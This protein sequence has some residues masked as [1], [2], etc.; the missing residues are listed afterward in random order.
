MLT[1]A[2]VLAFLFASLTMQCALA[3]EPLSLSNAATVANAD[4]ALVLIHGL[5]GDPKRSFGKW[6]ELIAQDP[7]TLA[8][9]GKLS[10]VAIYA[11]DYTADFKSMSTLEEVA[12]GAAADLAASSIFRK[13][14]HVWFVAHSMGGLVLKRTFALWKLQGKTVLLDRVVGV[15]MLGVPAA[16]APLADLVTSVSLQKVATFF[17]WNGDLVKELTTESGMRYLDSLENDWMS[18]RSARTGDSARR[19]TPYVSCGYET[20]PQ[21]GLASGLLPR[22]LA[23]VVP[24]LF[25]S[26]ICDER[27]GFSVRHTDL[28]EPA[29]DGDSIHLWLRGF[30][31]R[32]SLEGFKERRVSLTTA[33][34]SQVASFVLGRV[35]H[36][37]RALETGNLDTATQLPMQPEVIVFADK[38]SEELAAKLVLGGGEF[39]GATEAD[40]WEAVGKANKCLVVK[41]TPNRLRIS[42]KVTG[43]VTRCAFGSALVCSGQRCD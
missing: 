13:H 2:R 26:S 27:R 29:N 35:E 16:G 40:L 20:K 17:G 37:N 11:V 10:D 43:H 31:L 42:L 7:T 36:S 25:T 33:P 39:Y 8:D 19:T 38:K 32:S 22:S 1:C 41:A 5:A 6:A 9:H 12:T 4:R 23:M 24:K 21:F 3:A 28:T 34:P 18:I 14:R 15:G 30:L